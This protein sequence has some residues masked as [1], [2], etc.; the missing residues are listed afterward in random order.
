MLIICDCRKGLHTLHLNHEHIHHHSK[1]DTDAEDTHLG[2]DEN[3]D[4]YL[5]LS[6]L[7]VLVSH[8]AEAEDQ[9]IL[10]C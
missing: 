9:I 7:D 5:N 1:V 6:C 4:D 8:E 3:S 2:R 10:S